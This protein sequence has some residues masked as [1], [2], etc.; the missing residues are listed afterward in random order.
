MKNIFFA[1]IFSFLFLNSA[2]AKSDMDRYNNE[3]KSFIHRP[4]V[5]L[6]SSYGRLRYKF[7]KDEAFLKA[8]TAKRFAAQHVAM[9]EGF[10]TAGLTKVQDIFDFDF[11]AGTMG[12]SHG[13]TCVFPE[14]ID[15][16]LEYSLPT[17]YILNTLK[18]GSCMYEV[19]M[20]HEKTHM[21]IYIEGLDYF[22]PILKNYV[23]QL[24]DE[25]G[26]M[27]AARGESVEKT[28][29][30]LNEKYL[31]KVQDKIDAWH[32][33]VETEQLKLDTAEH[34]TMENMIC[35]Y[36]EETGTFK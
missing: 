27:V 32:S 8:E 23:E 20:R 25:V 28:A 33:E 21:Q 31:K 2:W 4:K 16:R 29:K 30:A 34:Y 22:L 19:A 5:A 24:F 12:L 9:P 1:L 17:I 7:D 10:E 6:Y 11:T 14:T 3:C 36:L 35:Q 18:K 15:V 26:F 13:Y